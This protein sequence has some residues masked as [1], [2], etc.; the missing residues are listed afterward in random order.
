M[1]VRSRI[2]LSL[3]LIPFLIGAAANSKA[4]DK[5]ANDDNPYDGLKWRGIGPALTSGRI[6]DFAVNPHNP[7]EYFVAVA[8]GHVWKTVNAGITFEAVFDKYGAYAMGCVTIDPGN[9][10]TVWVG[11]GEAN[12]QR[13]LG[14]GNGVYKSQDGGKSWECMGLKESRQIG[15]ILVDP[16]NSD[17]VYVAAE[18]SVWGPGG[19]R[20]LYKTING[21]KTW[22]KVLTISENTGV[23]N[24]VC[25]PR[26]PDVLYATSEQRRR[27]VFTK[28]GGGPESAVYKST[29]AGKTWNKIM[30][31]LP[32]VD[33]GGMGIDISPVNPDVIY[34]IV[35]AALGESGFYRS[36]N[37]GASWE[38]MGDYASS[39]QYYNRI[40]CDPKNVD[41]IYSVETVSKVTN[42][43]GKTWQNLGLDNRHV[44]DHALWI[45]PSDTTH[46]MIGGDGGIYESY[47]GGKFWDFKEN[48]SVTQFYRVFADNSLPFYWVYGG[49]QDNNSLAGPSQTI[50]ED[51]I[52]HADWIVTQGGD[53]FWSAPDPTDSNIIYAE[54]Q[55][56]GM[57]RYDKRSG[58]STPI[59]PEP[60]AGEESYKWNWDTPLIVSSHKPTRI[61]CAA[62]KVFCSD[63]RG[64]SWTVIS[65]DLTAKIDR[66]TWPV[67]GKYWGSDAV[68][69][70]KSTSLFGTIVSLAES[71]LDEN[72]LFVGT[73]DGLVQISEDR[74]TWRKAAA[75]PG[76]PQNTYISD[77]FPSRFDRKTVFVSAS[78][79]LRDDFKPYLFISH[80]LGASWTSITANLPQNGSIHTVIQDFV[81]ADLLFTGSEFGVFMSP[82]GGKKW[83][84]LGKGLPDIKITDIAI[85]ER[86]CDLVVATFGRGFYVLDNYAP[87]REMNRDVLSK[88]AHLFT[89]KE[90][91][92]FMMVGSR[93]GQGSNYFRAPNPDYGARFTVVLQEVPKTLKAL[94]QEKEKELFKAGK[95][96]PQPTAAEKQAEKDE[97][98]PYLRLTIRDA[99]NQ[100]VRVLQAPAQKG[101]QSIN[102]DLCHPSPRPVSQTEKFNPTAKPRSGLQILPGTYKVDLELISRTGAQSIAK[103]QSFAVKAMENASLPAP[104]RTA[105][106]AFLRSASDT[107]RIGMGIFARLEELRKKVETLKQATIDTP[108]LANSDLSARLETAGRELSAIYSRFELVS[109]SPS[110]EENPP[111]QIP[112]NNRME[113]LYYSHFQTTSAITEN[114]RTALEIL[115][116]EL[117]VLREQIAR[118][119]KEIHGLAEEMDKQG[120]PRTPEL[121]PRTR[122]N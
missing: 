92:Q 36:Q 65:D 38:K 81:K 106:V 96:I 102:W 27:H 14:Y 37:R 54:A 64:D 42:D 111:Q 34:L 22:D 10:H 117:P 86:E 44:D 97:T 75:L 80:D 74:K 19:D 113:T 116:K 68:A 107:Y 23:N 25:D 77:I 82:D 103:D 55:Y 87:L 61:Y 41:R 29:D 100:A 93:Y 115:Q 11:T 94:R 118:L 46:L 32:S 105:M 15:R 84:K 2:L 70:D 13:A 35:E 28:I 50:S 30:T 120:A 85:Q 6:A 49:T 69:K 40:F 48:L 71:K 43:A 83:H 52:V 3:L 57:C 72:L 24:I 21:G 119:D 109:D 66:N 53:G 5:K 90:A 45:D 26:N 47:D 58:E 122:V 99:D 18:G 4:A 59:R 73:D 7:K 60:R 112:L 1:T 121:L 62:N 78:N 12:H 108:S 91:R 9:P 20:G 56:G 98:A 51:G 31:G 17:V 76:V 39:G 8:S 67:M 114:E 63:D 95:P 104:D 110:M 89:V 79:M 33:I 16:R 88:D 101:L